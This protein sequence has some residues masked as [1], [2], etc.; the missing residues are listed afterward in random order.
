M[1]FY[2]IP[3]S[4]GYLTYCKSMAHDCVPVT[5]RMQLPDQGTKFRKIVATLLTPFNAF[6]SGPRPGVH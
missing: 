1:E 3:R 4:C 6:S 2:D 5:P